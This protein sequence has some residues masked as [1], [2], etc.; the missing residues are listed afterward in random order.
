MYRQACLWRLLQ[1]RPPGGPC[2]IGTL[3]VLEHGSLGLPHRTVYL[4]S[5]FNQCSCTSKSPNFHKQTNNGK[6]VLLR[7]S[8]KNKEIAN[9][10]T[11][12]RCQTPW[13]ASR[14]SI[15]TS[16]SDLA[17]H[18]KWSK[19]KYIK[20]PKDHEKSMITSKIITQMKV[21]V[22]GEP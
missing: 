10:K 6:A 4:H 7:I 12:Y 14:Y 13:C 16:S 2:S 15:H 22:R 9:V 11:S 5:T 1:Q 19:V 3:Q 20:G 17:G 21:A 8:G 18:N